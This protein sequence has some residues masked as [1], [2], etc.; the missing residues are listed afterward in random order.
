MKV[1][2]NSN[3]IENLKNCYNYSVVCCTIGILAK[4][5]LIL[6]FLNKLGVYAH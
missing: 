3:L 1:V 2:L 4:C 5:K 6:F